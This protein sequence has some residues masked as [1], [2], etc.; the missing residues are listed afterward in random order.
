MP[1]IQFRIYDIDVFF[2]NGTEKT[3]QF[4]EKIISGLMTLTG[5]LIDLVE[6]AQQI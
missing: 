1:F 3:P 6:C 5:E 4:E 2:V